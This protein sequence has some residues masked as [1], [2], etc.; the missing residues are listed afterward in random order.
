MNGP[1]NISKLAEGM[2]LTS[3]TLRHWEEE[4]L[5]ESLRDAGSGWRMYDAKAQSAIRI[6]SG[7]RKM[8][9]S[10]KEIKAVISDP[11]LT[12]LI[13]VIEDRE[14]ELR[15]QRTAMQQGVQQL[16]Q[17]LQFLRRL[18][19]GRD[20]KMNEIISEA[21]ALFMT[22]ESCNRSMKV[23]NFPRM[24]TVY[25]IAVSASPE[26]EAMGPVLEWIQTAGLL[27]TA[28]FFG[29]NVKPFPGVPG[30]AYGYGMCAVIPE[31]VTVPGHLQEMVLPGGLYAMLDSGD[32]IGA[33][34]KKLMKELAKDAKYCSDRSRL[35]LEEHIRN[36][37]P[38]GG[39][40]PYHL[41]LLEPVKER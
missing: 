5:Y 3:R 29:G 13:G 21:E 34:W 12:K 22:E 37:R 40:N 10:L 39:G 2:G 25:H 41:Q 32:D 9:I 33:S 4:G 36:D 24:R 1:I 27:G 11:T 35:C 23:V 18:D 30:A 19:T 20:I 17:V 14:A 6:T 7:L 38:D 26:D 15:N 31:G 16:E 8:G 28:R